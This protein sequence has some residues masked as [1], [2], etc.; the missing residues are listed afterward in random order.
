[1]VG[2]NNGKGRIYPW[3][4]ML[5][6]VVGISLALLPF[7]TSI[8]N[9]LFPPPPVNEELQDI[10]TAER[11]EMPFILPGDNW[12]V[13]IEVNETAEEI[14]E[15][16]EKFVPLNSSVLY[17]PSLDVM[18]NLTYGVELEDLR[19]IPGI[20]PQS[21]YPDTGNVSIAAHRDAWFRD[22]DKMESGDEIRLYYNN[23]VYLYSVDDVFIT[24]S[25]DWS[26]IDPTTEPALTL[27][28]CHPPGL[29][30]APYRLIARAYLKETIIPVE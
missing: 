4:G 25:R 20:Y 1:M 21:G 7:L 13:E 5:L 19:K 16:P 26:V 8:Y 23:K 30:A 18:T 17:I 22:L 15:F 14:E 12:D 2:R 29:G 6:L 11:D 9:R 27:T 24:H 10:L 28:T 3:I